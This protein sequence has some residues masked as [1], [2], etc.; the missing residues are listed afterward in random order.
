MIKPLLFIIHYILRKKILTFWGIF[1]GVNFICFPE[2]LKN[3]I[4]DLENGGRLIHEVDLYTSKYGKLN[5]G[6]SS[7]NVLVL[8][9]TDTAG[10]MSKFIPKISFAHQKFKLRV[11]VYPG[12][13][14]K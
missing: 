10:Q 2:M 5:F 14:L 4:F 6:S 13:F 7:K 3:L 11:Y 8:N 1:I 9:Q 12:Y